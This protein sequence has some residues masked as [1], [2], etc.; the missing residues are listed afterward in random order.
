VALRLI[1]WFFQIL[2]EF[3]PPNETEEGVELTPASRAQLTIKY[4]ANQYAFSREVRC[5]QDLQ[6]LKQRGNIR[7]DNA[8]KGIVVYAQ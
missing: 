8:P 2:Q 1:R 6:L 7:F 5:L 4:V 3:L